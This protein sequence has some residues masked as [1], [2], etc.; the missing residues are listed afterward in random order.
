[1]RQSSRKIAR[2]VAATLAVNTMQETVEIGKEAARL[3]MELQ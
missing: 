1:M 3:I 2:E